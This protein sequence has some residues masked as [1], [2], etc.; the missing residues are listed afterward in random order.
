MTQINTEDIILFPWINLLLQRLRSRGGPSFPPSQSR[1]THKNTKIDVFNKSS[2]LFRAIAGKREAFWAWQHRPRE[3]T[4]S[5][6]KEIKAGNRGIQADPAENRQGI[7]SRPEQSHPGCDSP[8][9]GSAHSDCRLAFT[10][11]FFC[12]I[13]LEK[14]WRSSSTSLH[15]FLKV[16][17]FVFF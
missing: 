6:P 10:S 16:F 7:H 5:Q 4:Q 12:F 2:C 1:P 3:G 14:G 13:L 15:R 17:S 11:G 9:D 8:E